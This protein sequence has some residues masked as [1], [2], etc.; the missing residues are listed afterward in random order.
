MPTVNV[1]GT[2]SSVY[3][4]DAARS[5]TRTDIAPK[6]YPA[7][8]Q[9]VP[10]VLQDRGVTSIGQVADNVSGVHAEASYGGNGATFFNIRGFSESNGLPI[11]PFVNPGLSSVAMPLRDM[12][13]AMVER[14][15]AR[16][17]QHDLPPVNALWMVENIAR[18]QPDDPAVLHTV[19]GALQMA[20]AEE[21]WQ[22]AD[23]DVI[24]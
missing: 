10:S 21:H 15:I 4:V 14:A 22:W 9:V 3:E 5:T 7:S 24:C 19:R 18:L 8:I 6:D 20:E 11:S 17:T 2:T 23:I 12:A 1:V 13:D 16:S